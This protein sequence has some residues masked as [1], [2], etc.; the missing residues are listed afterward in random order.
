MILLKHLRS[1]LAGVSETTM[2]MAKDHESPPLDSR[3]ALDAAIARLVVALHTTDVDSDEGRA[4]LIE[5]V[6]DRMSIDAISEIVFDIAGHQSLCSAALGVFVHC[7]RKGLDVCLRNPTANV[8]ELL[9][10]TNLDRVFRV[11]H[12]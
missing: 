9:R 1:A 4:A 2:I 6:D 8:I 12:D 10:R 5:A 7:H 11:Q 3:I